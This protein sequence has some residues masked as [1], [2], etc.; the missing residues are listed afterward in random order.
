MPGNA[1]PRSVPERQQRQ[2]LEARVGRHERGHGRRIERRTDLDAVE[3]SKVEA[4]ERADVGQRLAAR[5]S[6]DLRRAG[7]WGEGRIDE[8][9][10]EREEARRIADA[11]VDAFGETTWPQSRELL[12]RN[13]VYAEVTREVCIRGSGQ[14]SSQARLHGATRVDEALLDR[15]PDDAPVEE[16]L[17]EVLVP[18]VMV[19]V[20]LDQGQRSV[21]GRERAKLREQDRMVSAQTEGRGPGASDLLE[22]GCRPLERV[23]RRTGHGGHVPVVDEGEL[24]D[25][26][27]P[28]QWVVV[29][30]HDRRAPDP[31]WAEACAAPEGDSAIG[32]DADY[33]DVHP[34]ELPYVREPH[35]RPRAGESRHLERVRRPV[36]GHVR[37]R[38]YGGPGNHL[39]PLA[40]ADA[41]TV[42]HCSRVV[43][44]LGPLA[45]EPAFPV[46]QEGEGEEVI[47]G[48]AV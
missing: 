45:R 32:R 2:H 25:H 36:A 17:P 18:E 43:Q 28:K 24:R 7:A 22:G 27:D 21:H 26:V 35:E 14:R 46:G 4:G 1:R 44:P 38:L 3:P 15:S 8:V 10:V 47:A 37:A 13:G 33:G 11:L 9:D 34:V 30:Q 40:Y 16:L 29:P 42:E 23:D 20:E 48:T 12:V 31:L 39:L 6:P 5:G 41:T 19:R